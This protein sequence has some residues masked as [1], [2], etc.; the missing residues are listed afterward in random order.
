MIKTQRLTNSRPSRQRGVALA[1]ALVFLLVL[2]LMGVTGMRTAT[3]QERMAGNARDRA[4]AFQSA[5]EALRDAEDLVTRQ[6]LS[7]PSSRSW[8]YDANASGL[9][10]PSSNNVC[11]P[12]NGNATQLASNSFSGP[13]NT[14]PCYFIEVLDANFEGQITPG[15]SIGYV[16]P[17]IAET[18]YR[19]TAVGYGTTNDSRVVLQSVAAGRGNTGG[20][21]GGG[22]SG[23]GSQ[24]GGSSGGGSQGGGSQGGG[25]SGKGQNSSG[26]QGSGGGQGGSQ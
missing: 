17:Q 9:P 3:M 10:D 22:S 23:G 13:A 26:N 20:S 8:V 6:D 5:E 25:S 19:V 2:T 15:D 7:N 18:L 21:G 1:A 11:P 16:Q 4:V 14:R 24:G 12:T